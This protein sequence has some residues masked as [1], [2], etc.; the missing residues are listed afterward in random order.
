VT[1]PP[2]LSSGLLVRVAGAA[3]MAFA[4]LPIFRVVTVESDAPVR[5]ASVSM[6]DF[7]LELVWWGSLSTLLLAFLLARLFPDIPQR[8]G[9]AVAAWLQ[10]PPLPWFAI[11]VGGMA[12][13]AAFLVS[14]LLYHGLY[15]NVDEMASVIHGRYMAQGLL[16]GPPPPLAEG[17]LIPNTL[18]VEEG[19]VSQY[20]P[21]H[22]MAMALF[23]LLGVPGLLGPALIGAMAALVA[24]TLPRLLPTDPAVARAAAV[25]TAFSPLLLLLAGGALS[26]LTAGAALAGVAYAAVRARDGS[27]WWGLA[28]GIA[29]GLAVTSRPLVGLLLGTALPLALWWPQVREGAL[30]WGLRRA[31]ATVAGGLPFALA[32]GWYH[33]RLFGGP[34]RWGYL[35]AFG[36]DHGLG[37]HTD[38]WGYHYGVVEALA[39]T[40]TDLI[41]AGVQLLETPVP[42]TAVVG[43]LLL[44]APRLPRGTGVLVLWALV[45]AVGNAFYWFHAPRMYFEAAPA[46]IALGV[47]AVVRGARTQDGGPEGPKRRFVRSLVGWAAVV[48]LGWAVIGGVPLRWS[49][50]G[51]ADETLGRVTLPDVPEPGSALV[52]VHTS[53]NERMT[54]TLQGAGGMRQDSVTSVLRRNATCDLDRYVRMREQA[55]RYGREVGPLPV[56]D[57]THQAGSPPDLERRLTD[58]GTT[59][60][61]R[62]GGSFGPDC[63]REFHADRFGSVALAPL[64]WQGD[65]PGDERGR[66]MFVRDLG[67][68][69]NERIRAA[70]PG[71][72]S[73]VFAHLSP[74]GPPQV[75]PYEQAI[76]TLWGP[77]SQE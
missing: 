41:A 75:A 2:G 35:A 28:V 12:S 14:V 32:L 55:V 57:L 71:R 25:L 22:L 74:D 5:Q 66:P 9:R 11:G 18:I 38:P 40:S 60:R 73:W 7:T 37:F 67:P 49:N 30:D 21:S 44:V 69:K 59:L 17:W 20:P 61:I 26:H 4:F 58:S 29:V 64:L 16:A 65:L 3:L 76:A 45:P 77:T 23:S 62:T 46:W 63:A 24:L 27:A 15:T 53:W 19:W 51:W 10:R 72:T 54:S 36:E 42:L 1:P 70:F 43:C 31:A 34:T 56:L 13:A 47:M 48:S 8:M 33:T 68:E 6:A 39:F 50:A 52:F